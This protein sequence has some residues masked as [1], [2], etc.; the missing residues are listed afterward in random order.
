VYAS[1]SICECSFGQDTSSLRDTSHI[2]RDIKTYSKRSKFHTFVY[3]LI[4]KPN[5]PA[6]EIKKTRKKADKKLLQKP[7]SAFEGKIIRNINI[8]TLDPFGYSATDTSIARQ[9]Y[10]YKAGNWMHIKTQRITIINLLLFRRNQAFNSFLVKESERLIR[11]QGYVH[12][13]A[14][15]VTS[16]G[17]KSDSVDIFIRELDVWS[18]IPEGSISSSGFN[19]GAT[20]NNFVGTGHAF[21]ND[22]VRNISSGLNTYKTNYFIPNIRNTYINSDIY[23]KTDN[24]K[25]FTQSLSFD[26]P[27]Y[28]PTAKWAAGI[29]ASRIE[30]DSL[31]IINATILP[32][33][34]R[35][36][37]QDL[38]AG[39]A[40]QIIKGSSEEAL[41][42]SIIYTLRY[43][44]IQYYGKPSELYD[45]FH[46]YTSENFYLAGIG[47][48]TRKYVRD[49]YIFS[50][51]VIE[52]VPVGDVYAL[53]GGLQLKNNY[54]RFYL[55]ARYS[56]GNYYDWGYLSSNFEYGSFFHASV[57]EQGVFKAS[58]NYF[59]GLFEIGDWKFRQFIKPQLT[60]GLSRYSYDSLTLKD[61]Y[62]LD[63]F[64]S[65]G[66]I[67]TNRMVLT[68]QT[69]S[70]APWNFIGFHFGPFLI[71][72]IGMLG[73]DIGGFSSSKLYSQL[74]F[75]VLIKNENLIISTFQLSFSFYPTIPGYR[76]NV[77][78]L[79]S[80]KTSDFGFRDFRIGKP[81]IVVYE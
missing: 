59:T 48:S 3:Q 1:I 74:G 27:F 60:L 53:T 49:K 80:L 77:L 25:N 68:L 10:L 76:D 28:S 71:C 9:N 55:G 23:Y 11:S 32:L 52:D 33:R 70:Y 40:Q 54:T 29:S 2:Y 44:R 65:S 81:D 7:Y 67:G 14:F 20:D 17:R 16:A 51:G 37:T 78:K 58:I 57:P 73:N 39:F 24:N 21:Q 41:S 26:R 5:I 75:G 43:L 31:T 38:W 22:F 18:I 62:G 69:Q 47:L 72:S 79:N 46:I 61:G 13:V 8:V 42:T 50:Y 56:T 45:P 12:E 36:N 64:N 35:Y 30:I 4:F 15:F 66:L 19:I 34:L 63:G 6:L